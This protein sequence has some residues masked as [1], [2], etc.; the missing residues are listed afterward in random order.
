MGYDDMSIEQLRE[1]L[2]EEFANQKALRR[3][4]FVDSGKKNEY[5]EPLYEK[6]VA[7]NA[8]TDALNN[9]IGRRYFNM[10]Y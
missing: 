7:P 2:K 1:K 8:T 5:G 6:I 3:F 9:A 4:K 10:G